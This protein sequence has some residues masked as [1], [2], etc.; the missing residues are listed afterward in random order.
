[1]KYFRNRFSI[2]FLIIIHCTRANKLSN[3]SLNHL[4]GYFDLIFFHFFTSF[5]GG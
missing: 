2:R 5:E 3:A 4:I 1:M